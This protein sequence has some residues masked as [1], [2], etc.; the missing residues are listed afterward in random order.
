[1][2]TRFFTN[3]GDNT[4]L[5]KFAGVMS[6][7]PDIER[8]DALVGYLRA[9]GWF[10]IRPHLER[11]PKIRVLVGGPNS[12]IVRDYLMRNRRSNIHLYPEDWKT[13]PI[14]DVDTETQSQITTLVDRL[15]AAKQ[16][17]DH[18]T[19]AALDR[20][21]DDQVA[22]LYGLTEEEIALIIPPQNA[23]KP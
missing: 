12:S 15:L 23:T 5:A 10:A 13:L 14:P 11:V 8:F 19:A 6:H 9:S 4:L 17:G 7:N 18:P 1:M 21:I 20:E 22:K 2:S 16:S 3:A